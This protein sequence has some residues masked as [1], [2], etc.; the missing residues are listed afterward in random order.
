MQKLFIP[1]ASNTPTEQTPLR[2]SLPDLDG[3][4]WA[5]IAEL[6]QSR[7]LERCRLFVANFHLKPDAE[8]KI[9]DEIN[10]ACHHVIRFPIARKITSCTFI[11]RSCAVP[12]YRFMPPPGKK[13][14]STPA[15][16]RTLHLLITPDI[17]CANDT[18]QFFR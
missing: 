15:R 2:F 1:D 16:K 6:R 4:S 7:Y 3:L 11:A 18:S 8:T 17:S 9:A 14:Y 5:D 12:P 10:A 13:L